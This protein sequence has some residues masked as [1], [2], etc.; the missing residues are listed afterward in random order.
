MFIKNSHLWAKEPFKVQ[1]G[2]TGFNFNV[3]KYER[4]INADSDSI[5]QLT[6]KKLPLIKL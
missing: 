3:I 6:F 5:L 2:S 4:L 1:D